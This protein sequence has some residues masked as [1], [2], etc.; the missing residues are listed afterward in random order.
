M[1]LKMSDLSNSGLSFDRSYLDNG[2]IQ[3]EITESRPNND[4]D[5]LRPK[6][7]IGK[8][9]LNNCF[10]QRPL[11]CTPPALGLG[12]L[13]IRQ[14]G[15]LRIHTNLVKYDLSIPER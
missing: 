11:A 9:D 10:H 5:F 15:E 12:L 14:R 6:P 4:T 7:V 13:R 2:V 3:G 1:Q 8:G